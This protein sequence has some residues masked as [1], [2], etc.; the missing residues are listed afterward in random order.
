VTRYR[1]GSFLYAGRP[2]RPLLVALGIPLGVALLYGAGALATLGGVLLW[3]GIAVTVVV[4]V[5]I[6]W[7][8]IALSPP[9]VWLRLIINVLM[10]VPLIVI[11]MGSASATHAEI[12]QSRGVTYLGTVTA[13]QQVREKNN[14]TYRCTIQYTE[15]V[16]QATRYATVGCFNFNHVAEFDYVDVDPENW[17]SPELQGVVLGDIE[18]AG[19]ASL[20]A[21][22]FVL[23]LS[24]G[25]AGTGA[26]YARRVSRRQV[27]QTAPRSRPR[28]PF[29]R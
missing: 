13:V 1:R 23:V 14:I 10:V 4:A 19:P 9:K 5:G 20:V 28:G 12:L 26:L 7:A 24:A 11:P 25:V 2:R 29:G 15:R 22:I 21:V 3:L 17:V 18:G 8:L 6:L 27:A 16:T